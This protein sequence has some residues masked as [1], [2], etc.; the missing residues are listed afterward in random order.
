[1]DLVPGGGA[2]IPTYHPVHQNC[3]C[4]KPAQK[5]Q[6]GPALPGTPPPAL[7]GVWGDLAGLERDALLPHLLGGTSAEWLANLLSTHGYRISAST[8]R[9]YRRA[10]RMEEVDSERTGEGALSEADEHG[11][12]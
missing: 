9:T 12:E 11:V 2:V 8:I 3:R 6:D 10:L 1:M 4:P 5:P 7:A